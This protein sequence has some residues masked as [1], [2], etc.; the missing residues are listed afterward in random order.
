M[1]KEVYPK[2]A[3]GDATIKTAEASSGFFNLL[4]KSLPVLNLIPSSPTDETVGF[5]IPCHERALTNGNPAIAFLERAGYTVKVVETGTCC[6]MAGTF[7][8]KHGPLGYDLSMAVG[9]R[10]FKLF[11]ESKAKLVASESSVCAT[12]INDGTGLKVMHPLYFV[13]GT[14]DEGR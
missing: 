5:H 10:L 6:G 4:Q 3:P 1:L 14:P 2:L 7:G 8:M 13:K 11:G 9:E 12:Q